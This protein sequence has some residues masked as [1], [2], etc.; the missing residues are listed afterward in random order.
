MGAVHWDSVHSKLLKEF[1]SKVVHN[2]SQCI[3]EGS[4]EKRFEY[5]VNSKNQMTCVRAI[6]GHT[7]GNMISAKLM[8]HVEILPM[9]GKIGKV[10]RHQDQR[11]R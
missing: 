3:H 5:C 7:G 6:Q 10:P 2:H 8:G 1:D 4:N 11:K 9:H